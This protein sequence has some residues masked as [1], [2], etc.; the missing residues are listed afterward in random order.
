MTRFIANSPRLDESKWVLLGVPMDFTVSRKSGSRFGPESIRAESLN[1]ETFS[2]YQ[3]RD[4]SEICFYDL[5]DLSFPYGD[6]QQ[7]LDTVEKVARCLLARGKH[8]AA[9]GGEHLVSLPLIRAAASLWPDLR[10]VHFDAHADLR[11]KL[12]GGTLSHSSVMRHVAQTCL[13]EPNRL[14]QFG[15]RSG[16][17]EEMEWGRAHTKLHL[18]DVLE[19]LQRSLEELRPHP[20]YLS[21]DIDVVDPAAAPGTGTPEAGGITSRELLEAIRSMNGLHLVGFDLVEVAPDLDVNNVTSALAAK[22]I[23]EMLIQWG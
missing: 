7:A 21:I 9:L 11:T 13:E 1:L 17:S 22:C 10:V 20:V 8:I 15:I 12:R 19:P 3:N 16:C 6:V 18:F 5:E 4:L 14:H 23:R 2:P